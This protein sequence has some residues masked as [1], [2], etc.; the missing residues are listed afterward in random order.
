[1]GREE[2]Q[3]RYK[4]KRSKGIKGK[5]FLPE[6]KKLIFIGKITKSVGLKG[7]V[8]VISLSDF[9]KRFLSLD[10]VYIFDEKCNTLILN[11]VSETSKFKIEDI[12]FL[13]DYIR[14][15]FEN[16]NCKTEADELRGCF[17]TIDESEKVE[18]S[19]DRY[20]FF[21]LINL[22]VYSDKKEI[23]IVAEVENYGGDDLLSVELIGN[24]G[25]ILIPL[26]T[27]FIKKIDIKNKIIDIAL[28]DG[29][30]E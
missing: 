27:Q 14:V 12:V 4:K 24:K 9:D 20:Y 29:F 22:K 26:R 30:I 28:I 2:R 5:L 18:L 6:N 15:K 17:L 3:T 16:Y 25:K 11:R 23:G 13:N 8:K 21:D 19:T 7:Y 10:S 1:M